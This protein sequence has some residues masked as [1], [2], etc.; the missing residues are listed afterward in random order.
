MAIIKTENVS[1][2]NPAPVPIAQEVV[3]VRERITL[4]TAQEVTGN[5][6]EFAVLPANCVPVGYKL[7]SDDIDSV[8]GV[9]LDL[10]IINAGETAVSA[11][12]ADGGSKWVTASTLGQAGGLLLDTASAAA[13][14]I[15]GDVLPSSANRI[16]GVVFAAGPTTPVAGMIELEFSYRSVH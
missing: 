12:V 7:R 6:L 16:V 3:T 9:T 5:V 15:P 11:S 4:T 8:T 1:G 14:K 2:I 13:W 10:G